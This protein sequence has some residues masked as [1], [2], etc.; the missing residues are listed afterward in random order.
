[1]FAHV[2]PNFGKGRI[3]K[4]EM[5]ENLRD[6]P[7]DFL[8]IYF[9]DFSNGIIA[10][11][12]AVVGEDTIAVTPGVIKFGGRLFML[13]KK[14]E[15]PYYNTNKE[16]VVKIKFLPEENEQDFLC[17]RSSIFLDEHTAV[18]E[19]ELELGR[20]K[21]REGAVLRSDYVDFYD[22]NTEFNTI[23]IIHVQYAGYKQSTI[24]PDI[25]RYFVKIVEKSSTQNMFDIAFAMQCFGESI[26]DR[27]IILYYISKRQGMPRKP[28]TNMEIYRYLTIIVKELE[29]GIRRH[30]EPAAKGPS[31]IIID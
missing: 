16:M 2:L 31:R 22:F 8:R 1:M 6:F 20:F 28:M 15:I 29:S 13:E 12:E 14:V 17:T 3:L 30:V 19:D 18:G 27:D 24:N 9:R 26:V 4:R 11:G 23:N 5:L 21:L 7:R 25:L 10:G